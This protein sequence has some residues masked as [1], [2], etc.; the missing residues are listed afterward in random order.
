MARLPAYR[1]FP[2]GLAIPAA[3]EILA[4]LAGPAVLMSLAGP[5]VLTDPAAPAVLAVL[6][7]L[8]APLWL[9]RAP[10]TDHVSTPP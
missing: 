4:D 6:T 1:A 2:E 8:A 10:R 9:W 5:A 3:P 7:S